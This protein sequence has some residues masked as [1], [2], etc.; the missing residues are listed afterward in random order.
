MREWEAELRDRYPTANIVQ[1]LEMSPTQL[2]ETWAAVRDVYETDVRPEHNENRE[3]MIVAILEARRRFMLACLPKRNGQRVS[4]TRLHEVP[5]E[6]P[7]EA[8]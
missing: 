7:P 1:L 5:R 3:A 6:G 8:V 2:Q 4:R